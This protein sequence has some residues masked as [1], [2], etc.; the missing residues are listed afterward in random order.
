MSNL[1]SE[2]V[3]DFLKHYPPFNEMH[4]KDLLALS[5]EI[6]IV[7]FEKGR[8]IFSVGEKAHPHFYV[9]H[10][11]AVVL[12][13]GERIEIVDLCDEGDI[14]GLRPLMAHEDYIL[15]ARAFEECI[16]YAIPITAFRPYAQNYE[17]LGNFLIESF[18]SNTRNPYSR[19]AM[20]L[21]GGEI[22]SGT[23]EKSSH[24]LD[25][26]TV[27]VTKKIITCKL[28][29]T[30]K[31]VAELLTRKKVGSV[32]VVRK[33]LPVGI[34]TDKDLRNKI[35]TG[36]FPVSVAAS[37][38]M[39]SPVITYP[40]NLTITQA[41]MAMMKSNISHLC[42]T[43]DGTPHTKVAGILSKH[44]IMVAMGNNPAVLVKAIKRARKTSRLKPLRKS[45]IRLLQGYLKNN[46]PMSIILKVIAELNDACIKQVI[47]IALEKMKSPPPTSFAWLAMGSQGRGEQLLHTDQD[48]ALIYND[49]D[50]VAKKEVSI[51]F[52]QLAKT[53]NKGLQ[54][55]GYAYCPADMMA[56][57]PKW[58]MGIGE[59]KDT[60]GQWILNPGKE[61]VLLSS[62][63]FDY[64]LAYGNREL[65][66]E[67]SAFIF[68]RSSKNPM[69]YSH[70]AS[71]ALQNPS[72]S[73][74]FRQFLVEQDGAYK[75][76]FDLKRRALMPLTDAARV[77][78]LSHNIKAIN[79]TPDRFEKL[80]TLEENNRELY[81]ACSYATKA[82]LKFRA[83]QGL[84]HGDSGRFI[85][86]DSLSKEEKIKLKRTFRTIKEI[87]ELISIRF[88]VNNILA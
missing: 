44:D 24:L 71:G 87:Q 22:G 21:G 75:D 26:Q 1:I 83:R 11:G 42:L 85:A 7:Y 10:K 48:N 35:V 54:D 17:E 74:F 12:R 73:G 50:S 36:G 37:K 70:L 29:T 18:A 84:L 72:P 51:W 58:C 16:L 47:G 80:A 52:L 3:A 40:R 46:I 39:T 27:P 79:S 55:I 28:K 65:V 77:L 81:L 45:I 62:I 86:L 2:R 66:D 30:A 34:I 19:K 76:F 88:K 25:L 13:N 9:V 33:G 8:T 31:E 57:N 64:N 59:W 63:F 49:I 20:L 68:E 38:I 60:V 32:I 15:E 61:E 67:L 53:V 82:L 5:E 56:S 6:S 69:F 78:V 4:D 14:F 23:L 41:Q 43:E